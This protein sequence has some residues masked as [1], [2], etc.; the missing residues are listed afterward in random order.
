MKPDKTQEFVRAEPD[1]QTKK[2]IRP[3]APPKVKVGDQWIQSYWLYRELWVSLN[4]IAN[5]QL[6][7]LK[8]CGCEV[9]C[10]E[11][12]NAEQSDSID[13]F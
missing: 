4:G 10:S 13:L 7:A 11:F 6:E 5:V 8:S 1:I 2:N 12:A 3:H 9:D